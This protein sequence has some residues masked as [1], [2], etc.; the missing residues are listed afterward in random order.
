MASRFKVSGFVLISLLP[1]CHSSKL[2]L[3]FCGG[4]KMSYRQAFQ[5]EIEKSAILLL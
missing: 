2:K 5:I 4:G 1:Y 3:L